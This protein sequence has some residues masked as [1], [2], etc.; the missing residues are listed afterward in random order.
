MAILIKVGIL[1]QFTIELL[2]INLVVM[3]AVE[4]NEEYICFNHLNLTVKAL[5][6]CEELRELQVPIFGLIIFVEKL[7]RT[8]PS[9]GE[10]CS[11]MIDQWSAVLHQVS[12]K[13]FSEDFEVEYF[14]TATISVDDFLVDLG[15]LLF[16]I[17]NA[18]FLGLSDKLIY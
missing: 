16:G 15:Q 12:I 3:I 2:E 1:T 17:L 13:Q 14:L 11:Q 9:V 5:N 10:F 18:D 7:V 8:H 6:C 4:I